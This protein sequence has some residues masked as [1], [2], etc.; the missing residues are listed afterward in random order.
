MNDVYMGDAAVV[1]PGSG[2]TLT[3]ASTG[4]NHTQA[5]VPGATYAIT[6]SP[7]V[8]NGNFHFSVTGTILT[9]ANIEFVACVGDTIVIRIPDNV[10]VL[11]YQSLANGGTAWMR[12]LQMP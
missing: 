8:V 10:A 5:V 12:R 9:A 4:A 7:A 1:L 6:V 2:I 3:D 11:N